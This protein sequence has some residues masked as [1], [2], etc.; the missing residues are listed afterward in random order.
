MTD[1]P[2]E[3]QPVPKT[4]KERYI[5]A[6]NRVRGLLVRMI[7]RDKGVDMTRLRVKQV[8]REAELSALTQLLVDKHVFT[9]DEYYHAAAVQCGDV[10]ERLTAELDAVQLLLPEGAVNGSKEGH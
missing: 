6:A 1:T 2:A 10:R 3:E 7:Q 4:A 8:L 5:A 9:I